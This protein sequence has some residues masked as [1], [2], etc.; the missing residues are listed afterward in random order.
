MKID[1]NLC[2]L[3]DT[4]CGNSI[5]KVGLEPSYTYARPLPHLV[6]PAGAKV[7]GQ[8]D[9]HWRQRA[10]PSGKLGTLSQRTTQFQ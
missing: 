1:C 7:V 10:G 2:Q 8:V 5:Y 3:R 9:S 6:L 4:I